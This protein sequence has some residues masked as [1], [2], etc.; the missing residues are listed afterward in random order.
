MEVV[1]AHGV[2]PRLVWAGA[3][4]S[5]TLLEKVQKSGEPLITSDATRDPDFADVF[6]LQVSEIR[7]VVCV[8]FWGRSEQVVGMLYADSLMKAGA[9]DR[10]AFTRVVDYARRL[11][12]LLYR[13]QRESTQPE[14]PQPGPGVRV[15]PPSAKADKAMLGG[16]AERTKPKPKAKSVPALE[17]PLREK[18]V[19]F[20]SLA[21][22]IGAGIP[23]HRATLLLSEQSEHPA[24]ASACDK[25]ATSI[26]EGTSFT[27]ALASMPRAFSSF[28]RSLMAVAERSGRL[29]Q[30]LESVADQMESRHRHLMKVRG[31]LT[32]PC[33]LFAVCMLALVFVPPYLLSGQLQLLQSSG[34]EQPL[35]TRALI[36]FS[37]VARSPLFIIACMWLGGALW[38]ALPALWRRWWF[39]R[40][41]YRRLIRVPYLG[42]MLRLLATAHFSRALALCLHSG[43]L[44]SE[45]LPL[46][47]KASGQPLLSDAMPDAVEALYDGKG[48]GHALEMTGFFPVE[49]MSLVEVGEESGRL[50]SSLDWLAGMY[51]L[52]LEASIETAAAAFEPLLMVGMGAVVALILV[53]TL[54]PTLKLVQSL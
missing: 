50:A 18:V 52:E 14:P 25:M 9:F 16:T 32:Y 20:R 24:V 41:V 42:R 23:L 40:K 51:E 54:L 34:A 33:F 28:E 26:G 44:L 46:A 17:I 29:H 27:G 12:Q 4:I 43:V 3:P 31:A 35:L 45:A 8:P 53:G 49:F 7:S 2:E 15:S 11:E 19:L 37:A 30:V 22:M 48:L 39:K 47:G 10:E 5:T 1:A 38:V 36:A 6:S 21:T 13:E